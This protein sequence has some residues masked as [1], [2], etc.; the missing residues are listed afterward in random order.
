[1]A[2]E[3]VKWFGDEQDFG[4]MAPDDRSQEL[5]LHN[6]AIGGDY[7]LLVEGARDSHNAADE[8]G[9]KAANVQLT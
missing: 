4:V 5:F 1:M 7:R 8:E 3:S 6:R 2:P 9:P